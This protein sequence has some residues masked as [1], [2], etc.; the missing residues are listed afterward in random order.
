[1]STLWLG[2][3]R[4]YPAF[5]LQSDKKKS[6]AAEMQSLFQGLTAPVFWWKAGSVWIKPWRF[7]H[8]SFPFCSSSGLPAFLD[9]GPNDGSALLRHSQRSGPRGAPV[10]L[11]E[12]ELLGTEFPLGGSGQ[13]PSVWSRPLG[14]SAKTQTQ[15]GMEPVLRI[16]RV[17]RKWT[18]LCW[19]GKWS[20][21]VRESV[22]SRFNQELMQALEHK[23]IRCNA[24]C[25]L[26]K[27]S[28]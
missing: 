19:Q 8:L 10:C 28:T 13:V 3:G 14:G 12:R 9:G 23:E 1:M 17:H 26:L 18:T 2:S 7:W 27:A 16:G 4:N 22:L 11:T 24:V 5:R 25:V 20:V 6:N 15:L 21:T